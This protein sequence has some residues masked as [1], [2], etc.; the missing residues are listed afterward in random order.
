MK[1][2]GFNLRVSDAKKEILENLVGTGLPAIVLQLI[3]NEV[4]FNI[5]NQIIQI[6]ETERKEYEKV[7]E[8]EEKI[9]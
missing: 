2:K 3:L 7:E 5:D 9:T 1:D 6:V 4:K 8:I